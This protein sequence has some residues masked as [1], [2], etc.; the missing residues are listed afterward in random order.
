MEKLIVQFIIFINRKCWWT[1][2]FDRE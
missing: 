2:C 1:G